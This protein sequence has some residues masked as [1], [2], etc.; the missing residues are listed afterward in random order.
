VEPNQVSNTALI[1]AFVR[2]HH[3]TH[4]NPKIFNDFLAM[5][6]FTAEQRALFESN[7]AQAL[8]FFDPQRA[9]ECLDTPSALAAFTRAQSGPIVLSRARYAEDA[10]AAAV[11]Q[12]ARQYVLLG[13]GMD[14]FVFRYPEMLDRLM[15]FEIDHPG[16]QGFKRRRLAELGWDEPPQVRYLPLDFTQGSVKAALLQA[17]YDPAAPSFFSWLGV[18]YYLSREVVFDTLRTIAGVAPAGSTI[19]F[20]YL[21]A[22]A[23]VAEKTAPRVKLMQEAAR[24]SG[25]PMKTGFDPS[26]LAADL[27]RSGLRLR[28][29]LSPGDI[30]AHYFQA[31][32]D[33]F[34]A[35]EH[36]HFARAVVA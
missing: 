26:T 12:G 11:E 28:E 2:A 23:F 16:T 18:T 27:T 19:V 3:A 6:L 24:R 20:D 8:Q 9:A 21:D 36:I 22:D 10:L 4:D 5:Q 33:G 32:T 25:E 17:G 7:L 35:F 1:S 14:T 31:R 34:H 13:A 29:T 15:V 30:E